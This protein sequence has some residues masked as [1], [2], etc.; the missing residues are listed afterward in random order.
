MFIYGFI[1][2]ITIDILQQLVAEKNCWIALKSTHLSKI[3]SLP[4]LP[5]KRTLIKLKG[6][7]TAENKNIVEQPYQ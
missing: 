4:Q 6:H 7:A 5:A 2:S 1:V 3:S